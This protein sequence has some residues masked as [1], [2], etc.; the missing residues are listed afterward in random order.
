VTLGALLGALLAFSPNPA[1]AQATLRW[2]RTDPA[3]TKAIVLSADEVITWRAKGQLVFLLKGR[4]WVEQDVFQARM[5]Q[6]VVWINEE[7]RKKQGVY[8]VTVFADGDVSLVERNTSPGGDGLL[9]RALLSLTTRGEIKVNAYN[10]T[11][12]QK[13]MEQDPLYLAALAERDAKPAPPPPARPAQSA[14]APT[15]P[16]A[17]PA[18]PT[19]AAPAQLPAALLDTTPG[20]PARRVDGAFQRVSGQDDGGFPRPLIQPVQGFGGPPPG[21]VPLPLPPVAPAP[22]QPGAIPEVGQGPIPELPPPR[23]LA[24]ALEE[25]APKQ[26]VIRPRS[27]EALKAENYPLPNGE[28]IIVVTSGVIVTVIDP[29]NDSLIDVEADRLALWTRGDF[30]QMFKGISGPQ[31]QPS[32]SPEFY[33]SGNVQLRQQLGLESRLVLA[34]EVYYDVGRNVAIARNAELIVKQPGLP[35]PVH[36]QTPQLLQQNA[37]LFELGKSL[38]NASKLPYDPELRLTM[39]KASLEQ[40]ELVKRG[41]FGFGPAR[42]DPK[43]GQPLV[44]KDQIFR[45][46]N[47]V[48]WVGPIPIFYLPYVQGN[49]NDPLGPL[50]NLGFN[51]SRIF[52]FQTFTSWDVYDLFGLT[53]VAGTRWRLNVDYMTRRGPALGTDYRDIGQDF[54]G[55]GGKYSFMLRAYGIYDTA[56]DILG[57]NRGIQTQVNEEGLTVPITHPNWRGRFTPELNVFDMNGGLFL[58]GKL[59]AISDRNFLEQY[60]LNEWTTDFNQETYLYGGQRLGIFS[61]TALTEVNIRNWITE[62][63][64]LPRADTFLTGQKFWDLFTWNNW[65]SVGYAHL[66]PT[67][68]PP[69]PISNTDQDVE[70]GRADTTN[71]LSLP[72]PVGAFKLVPYGVLD[73]TYYTETLDNEQARG[74]FYGGGG[75]RGSLPLSRLFPCV[76]SEFF[77]VNGLYHKMLFSFNYYNAHSDVPYSQLPQLDRMNDDATDQSL[78]DIKPWQTAFNPGY[79]QKLITFPGFNPQVLAIQQLVDSRIDTRDTIEVLQLELRQRLQTKRGLPGAQHIVDWMTLDMSATYFPSAVRD[80]FGESWSFLQYD[81]NWYV[82]D[83]LALY[84]NAWYEPISQ[85]ARSYTVGFDINRPDGARLGLSYR[86]LDPLNSKNIVGSIGYAFSPKYSLSASTG[87]DI[88]NNV[89]FNSVMIVRTGTDVQIGVGFGYN[90]IVNTFT[91]M[92]EI[93]PNLLPANKRVPGSVG[94]VL[95]QMSSPH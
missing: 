33:L 55:L 29:E 95:Q 67:H 85:G 15:A 25:T 74:R 59:S 52:G 94:G 2:G 60:F 20:Q 14:P 71:E 50:E 57:N 46:R 78:R 63:E 49:V 51:Y 48:V 62:T 16:S 4:A 65:N 43:T 30:Q 44:Q 73:L 90:S 77:N 76:Q 86:Q 27:A 22:V 41:L 40:V 89:Q 72:L 6:A 32:R 18:A 84:S 82:G 37:K 10:R 80:N 17:P 19:Q 23:P 58:Q 9:P 3:T 68:Q 81:W 87:Y 12:V 7:A 91:F 36:L 56:T 28:T 21:G 64:W 13:N 35:D 47:A 75:V 69:P 39:T 92:F 8:P 54:F 53:P 61:W 38:V 31:G 45:G 66:K 24:P 11:I 5:R 1:A 34:D 79:G 70:T 88:G 26:V 83:R 93:Y 42:I